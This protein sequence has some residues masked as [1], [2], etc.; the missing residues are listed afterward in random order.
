M[1]PISPTRN[2][3]LGCAGGSRTHIFLL[4]R[5]TLDQLSY[6]TTTRE[7]FPSSNSTPKNHFRAKASMILL[8]R[9]QHPDRSFRSLSLYRVA[10]SSS[11]LNTEGPTDSSRLGLHSIERPLRLNLGA[12]PLHM[13]TLRL[14]LSR[15]TVRIGSK[16]L[17]RIS[18]VLRFLKTVK[19]FLASPVGF[20]PTFSALRTRLP[21]H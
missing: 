14:W 5:Q 19:F 17:H 1:I 13:D 3:K 2:F 4:N 7:F 11:F 20:E 18:K 9:S 16:V 6:R 15:C 10:T 21:G 12:K 8:D